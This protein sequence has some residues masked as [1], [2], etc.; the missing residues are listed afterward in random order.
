MKGT[1]IN[2]LLIFLGSSIGLLLSKKL[3][4][5]FQQSIMQVLGI[6]VGLIGIQM[7]FKSEEPIILIASLSLG[8]LLGEWWDLDGK[9]SRLSERISR[10]FT[11][12]KENNF[13]QGFITTSVLYC[14]GA[15][16]ILGAFEEGLGGTP[17]ILYTKSVLDGISSIFFAASLGIGVPFSALAVLLYQGSLT[18]LASTFASYFTPAAISELTGTGGALLCAIS[19]TMLNIQTIRIAN[20]LP[21][22][23]IAVLITLWGI[24]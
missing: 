7:A 10:R 6:T 20:L 15:M 23:P 3:N 5:R 11:K 24:F 16:A 19:L 9:I 21:A 4:V 14:A 12:N 17:T 8:T 18:L 13:T 22:L 2:S 1:L